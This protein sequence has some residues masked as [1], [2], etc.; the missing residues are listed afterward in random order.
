MSRD[1]RCKCGYTMQR[2]AA[3]Y[4]YDLRLDTFNDAGEV[5][6]EQSPFCS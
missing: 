2:I 6:S 4:G 3:D 1:W 5:E